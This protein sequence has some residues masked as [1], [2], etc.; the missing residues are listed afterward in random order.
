MGCKTEKRNHVFGI[1]ACKTEN[2]SSFHLKKVAR[3]LVDGWDLFKAINGP[4]QTVVSG[5]KK[6]V[7]LGGPVKSNFSS[8]GPE[9]DPSAPFVGLRCRK[10]TIHNEYHKMNF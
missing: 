2:T 7:K 5:H 9:P 10:K 8:L 3:W 4:A 1:V 6:A